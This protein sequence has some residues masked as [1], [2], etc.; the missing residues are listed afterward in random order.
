M[1]TLRSLTGWTL[2]A[3]LLA[4]PAAWAATPDTDAQA[5]YQ[6]ERAACLNGQSHQDRATCLREAGAALNEARHG[7]LNDRGVDYQRNALQRCEAL[8]AQ[9]RD[10]CHA[11]MTGQ[12]TT[13]GSV[14]QGAI[15]RE[16]RE[17]VP[18]A[19]MTAPT[20]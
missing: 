7:M 2:T 4:A 15:L 12:G 14:E 10:A 13:E 11:R 20:Q 16:Y 9:D 8:P 5:R 3:A 17:I 18:A 1:G 6:Q 19:S